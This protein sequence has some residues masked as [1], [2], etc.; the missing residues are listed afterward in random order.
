MKLL[1]I[2]MRVTQKY[3][4]N[5]LNEY[6]ISFEEAAVEINDYLRTNQSCIHNYVWI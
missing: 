6:T 4:Q 3:D 2:F 1:I 5:P